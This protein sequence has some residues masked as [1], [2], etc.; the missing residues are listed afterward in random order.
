MGAF[1]NSVFGQPLQDLVGTYI[2]DPLKVK[3]YKRLLLLKDQFDRVLIQRQID[4][5][6]N[7][8]EIKLALPLWEAA[9][10]EDDE[11]LRT[12][13]ANLLASECDPNTAKSARTAFVWANHD[14]NVVPDGIMAKMNVSAHYRY[15]RIVTTPLGVH[16]VKAF[17]PQ[18]IA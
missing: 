1:F 6:T 7:P 8:P 16:F 18:P 3:R 5:K 10:L 15:R 4:G 17:M 14:T 2:A 11:L 9:S 13:F 12:L